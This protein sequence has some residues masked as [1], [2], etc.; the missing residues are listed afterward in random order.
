[1]D[2]R[3]QAIEWREQKI[4]IEGEAKE[5]NPW[6]ERAGWHT[7][8]AGI[9]RDKLLES[10]DRLDAETEPILTAIWQ[11]MD[12]MIQHCQQTV[13]YRVGI[14]IRLEAIRTEKYQTRYHLLQGYMNAKLVQEYDRLW[15]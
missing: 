8:L 11:A 1:M 14:F 10:V 12:D 9:E 6:L 5:V 15:K 3:K 4:V 2:Q 13:I 7:Y